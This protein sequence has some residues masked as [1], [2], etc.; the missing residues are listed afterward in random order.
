MSVMDKAPAIIR[1]CERAAGGMQSG[2]QLD[3]CLGA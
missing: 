2:M 3:D 1:D